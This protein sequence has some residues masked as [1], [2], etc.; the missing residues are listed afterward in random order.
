VCTDLCADILCVDCL[1]TPIKRVQ[2]SVYRHIVSRL[3][4]TLLIG[5]YRHIVCRPHI[6]C[7]IHA[8]TLFLFWVYC[9]FRVMP[10]DM[11]LTHSHSQNTQH[12]Q[13]LQR[14][15]QSKS[16]AR[17]W[18]KARVMQESDAK[19]GLVST[20]QHPLSQTAVCGP[21]FFYFESTVH[22]ESFL[23]AWHSRF[24]K[25]TPLSIPVESHM[26]K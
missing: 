3:I 2:T 5:V 11:T 24:S 19:Q 23:W 26:K 6:V 18:C 20:L 10:L 7:L 16:D 4:H 14:V 9:L 1:Y 12:C 22:F 15:M 17:E 21:H 8:S 25:Y 13:W